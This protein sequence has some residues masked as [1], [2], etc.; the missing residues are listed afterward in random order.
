MKLE[1]ENISN[2]VIGV[3]ANPITYNITVDND[4]IIENHNHCIKGEIE[5]LK[6]YESKFIELKFKLRSD[7][8]FFS[9]P[10]W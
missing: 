1:I 3:Q 5:E 6:P 9:T 4:I 10:K 8:K 7:T 2:K